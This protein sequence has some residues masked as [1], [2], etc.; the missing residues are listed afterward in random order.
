M[1]Q[2][3]RWCRRCRKRSN[4]RQRIDDF[5]IGGVSKLR[6]F[7]SNFTVND[8]R[9]EGFCTP[10][11]NEHDG[12]FGSTNGG[13]M[14]EKSELKG[15]F[16]D[17][18]VF[19][20]A[21]CGWGVANELFEIALSI[22]GQ[23]E[24]LY[25]L[26]FNELLAGGQVSEAKVVFEAALDRSFHLGNFLYKDLIEKL[27]KDEKLEEASGILHKL[28][29]KGYKFDPASFM[30]VVDDLGKRGN[31]HEADELAEKMLEMA[32]GRV[33]NKIYRKE[34]ESIHR[35]GTKYGGDD[36][37][38]IVHRD[39]GSGITLKSLKGV[40]EEDSGGG[41]CATNVFAAMQC[42]R[43]KCKISGYW[44]GASV[45]QRYYW[46]IDG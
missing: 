44:L 5:H 2:G 11:N 28:I 37:Q 31:K 22:C 36:W 9:F 4:G 38:T 13:Q 6:I 35:K 12:G 20:I 1:M 33:E 41:Y 21:V 27:C 7:E 39:V 10:V 16:W 30:P 46:G 26:M 32:S 18:S 34:K 24:A 25:S 17:V 43:I 14:M 45:N 23:K 40:Q 3:T 8:E 15:G 42:G 19:P 29:I